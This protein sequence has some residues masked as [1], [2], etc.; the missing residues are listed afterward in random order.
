MYSGCY[1]RDIECYIGPLNPFKYS[2]AIQIESEK[3][4]CKYYNGCKGRVAT[5]T[6][7]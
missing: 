6:H 4:R 2:E 1:G 7:I 5:V 3:S